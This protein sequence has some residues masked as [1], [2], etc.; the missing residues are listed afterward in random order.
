M[1][2]HF[3]SQTV[4]FDECAVQSFCKLFWLWLQ[5]NTGTYTSDACPSF[6]CRVECACHLYLYQHLKHK[7][8][9]FWERACAVGDSIAETSVAIVAGKG[10][11]AI[12]E[13]RLCLCLSLSLLLDFVSLHKFL[14]RIAD[15]IAQFCNSLTCSSNRF[16]LRIG[17][18]FL[19]LR[20]P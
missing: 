3:A 19:K 17:M 14:F 2:V 16:L 4:E 18:C 9:Q 5:S 11:G 7:K 12:R 20:T 13:T 1:F 6:D 15:Q 8:H 10:W